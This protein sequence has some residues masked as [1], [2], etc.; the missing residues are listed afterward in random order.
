MISLLTNSTPIEWAG[1]PVVSKVNYKVKFIFGGRNEEEL[2]A[3]G[4]RRTDPEDPEDTAGR[5]PRGV[6]G[7]CSHPLD[8]SVHPPPRRRRLNFSL[9]NLKK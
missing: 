5:L 6:N 2:L 1:F 7:T 9:L 4:Y 3:D 8:F